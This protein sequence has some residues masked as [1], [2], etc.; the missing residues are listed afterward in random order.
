MRPGHTI[1]AAI[2][3]VAALLNSVPA[4]SEKLIASLSNHRVLIT[5]NYTGEELVVFGTIEPD[6]GEPRRN[7][8]DVVI[9]VTGPRMSMVTFRKERFMG[10]WINTESRVF[11][12]APSYLALLSNRPVDTIANAETRRRLQL[13]LDYFQLPQRVGPDVAD[14]VPDDPFRRAFLRIKDERNLYAEEPNGVT[15]LTPG[16][17]RA[18]IPLPAEVATGT[19]QVDVKLLADG[20]L[21]ARTNTAF[22]IIKVGFE[23]F[24]ATASREHGVLYGFATAMMALV[25]G[26]LASVVFRKD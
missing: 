3:A 5:S 25:T 17:Y 10:I 6:A 21:L 12:E 19:Y 14:V 24:V 18:S 9:T 7:S 20:V 11:V 13:G 4:H 2:I 1:L 16:L 22:E 8:Y 15:F 23:Q 26:W